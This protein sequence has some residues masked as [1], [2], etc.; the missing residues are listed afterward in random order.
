MFIKLT[1]LL[2]AN[3]THF[4]SHNMH[5]FSWY[6]V[7]GDTDDHGRSINAAPALSWALAWP[8]DTTWPGPTGLDLWR[9]PSG[10]PAAA[11]THTPHGCGIGP[12]HASAN[13]ARDAPTAPLCA[14]AA[15]RRAPS[16]TWASVPASPAIRPACV[17]ASRPAR[18]RMQLCEL[19]DGHSHR[20]GQDGLGIGL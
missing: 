4:T 2:D 17:R 8:G 15:A 16:L 6:Y 20:M 5:Y 7:G 13:R 9:P 14:A 1:S 11:R 10:H 18:A 3:H 19:S 12:G